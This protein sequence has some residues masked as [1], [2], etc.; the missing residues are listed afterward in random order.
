MVRCV[1]FPIANQLKIVSFLGKP[2]TKAAD[3]I[4]SEAKK[5]TAK[6][7]A[8]AKQVKVVDP[9]EENDDDSDDKSDD[10]L[11]SSDEEVFG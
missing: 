11:D 1:I 9:K 7:G 5:A 4:V 3:Q 2:E 10:D 6:S 8:S